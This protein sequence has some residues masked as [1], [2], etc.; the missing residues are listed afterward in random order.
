MPLTVTRFAPENTSSADIAKALADPR[1]CSYKLEYFEVS[2]AGGV[3][4][5]I[6]AYADADWEDLQVTVS[7]E[8]SK[9]RLF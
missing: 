5:D 9:H 1:P 4:R 8:A 3:A 7:Q 2:G 6:L